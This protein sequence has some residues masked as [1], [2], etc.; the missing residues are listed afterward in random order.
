LEPGGI[1]FR[2]R[3]FAAISAVT[4]FFR[5]TV[6]RIV[7]IPSNKN[8]DNHFLSAKPQGARMLGWTYY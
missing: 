5:R 2:T 6:R 7:I 8:I 4:A 1:F 3:S